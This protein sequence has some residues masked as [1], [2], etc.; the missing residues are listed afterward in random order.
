M[1]RGS[2][3]PLAASR[4]GRPAWP[5]EAC[6]QLQPGFMLLA[7]PCYAAP[8]SSCASPLGTT[9][10]A[11]RGTKL[12]DQ[13]K[14]RSH[15]GMLE[16]LGHVGRDTRR[17]NF[18]M[19]CCSQ[20][21]GCFG[22]FPCYFG[23]IEVFLG[24]CLPGRQQPG[25]KPRRKRSVPEE[26]LTAETNH[27]CTYLCGYFGDMIQLF[28]ANQVFGMS[29]VGQSGTPTLAGIGPPLPSRVAQ[30]CAISPSS[31]QQACLHQARA[32]IA[33]LPRTRG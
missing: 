30:T 16:F 19:Y 17:I 15:Q 25:R 9:R 22:W 8:V 33:W 7:M 14:Y 32:K 26:I 4:T 6:T 24:R 12:L 13:L 11:L 2:K 23:P 28:V 1:R 27:T 20:R 5:S 29:F 21:A 10:L 3:P 18:L 31:H